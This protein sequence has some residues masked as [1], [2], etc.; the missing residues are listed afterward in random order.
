MRGEWRSPGSQGRERSLPGPTVPMP[1]TRLTLGGQHPWGS[2][3]ACRAPQHLGWDLGV[4]TAGCV[5]TSSHSCPHHSACRGFSR[6]PPPPDPAAFPGLLGRSRLGAL[7]SW[8]GWKGPE[9]SGDERARAPCPGPKAWNLAAVLGL[10]PA[11]CPEDK[12]PRQEL[13]SE[14]GLRSPWATRAS[15]PGVSHREGAWRE[16]RQPGHVRPLRASPPTCN[17][18]GALARPSVFSTPVPLGAAGGRARLLVRRAGCVSCV[19]AADKTPHAL[20]LPQ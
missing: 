13:L 6:R 12:R 8:A 1:G 3:A 5:L 7:C 11:H 10:S 16:G 9:R 4:P 17:T 19:D 20:L 18:T 15:A 14:G 2:D